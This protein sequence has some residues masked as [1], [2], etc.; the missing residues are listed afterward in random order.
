MYGRSENGLHCPLVNTKRTQGKTKGAT[1]V[2]IGKLGGAVLTS[3]ALASLLILC[4]AIVVA[5]GITYNVSEGHEYATLEELR[6]SGRPQHN[7][8]IV[9]NGDDSS[10]T[11]EGAWQFR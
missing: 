6:I 10:L 4:S 3:L 8:T 1:H 9:L 11:L 2:E 5:Q 7:D